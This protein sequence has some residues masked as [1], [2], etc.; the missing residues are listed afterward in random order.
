MAWT[1]NSMLITAAFLLLA[2]L[3]SQATARSLHE[4]SLT[5]KH[6]QWMVEHG[7]VYK[8]EAEK[9]KRFKIFK[10][11]VEYIEAFN[12]AGNKSYVLGI[13]RF[14]DLTNEEFLSASTGYNYKPR[15]D[16]SQ[17]TSFRYADVSD[18][19][20]SMNWRQKGA[21]TG[22]KDQ[23]ACGCCWAFSTVAAVEGIHKLKAG[24]LISLSEQQLVDCDTSSNH[25]CSGGRMDSAFNFIASNGIATESEYPYQGADGT[26]NNDQGA[27]QITGYEDVPQNNEDALLQ[28]VSKQPVSVGIEG[29]G[30]DFKNYK[31][32]VFSGD[33][34]N[35]LDHA[36]TLVGYGTSE[37]GT[38]YWLVK[39]SWGTSWGEDGYMRLQRHTGAPEGLCGIASQ[40]SYPTA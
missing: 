34:G 39:N 10:E 20:P 37:D 8:D 4:A 40:A 38:K 7:R 32:G 1:F 22:V 13:N 27:V 29:S 6:E 15:K 5:E 12:K 25:G 16:V 28:A 23:A 33:C 19:P 18:A 21:V 26:C 30:M 17:G 24:E 3:A 36:V 35:N 11:T 9:A 31:S 14:S 2:M